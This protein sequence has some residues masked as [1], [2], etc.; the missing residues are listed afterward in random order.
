MSTPAPTPDTAPYWAAAAEGRL[1][2]QHCNACGR[3][4]FYPR[5]FCRHCFSPDVAWV[6]V[7]GNARLLSYVIARKPLRGF[8]PVSP[9]IAVVELDEGPRL[10]TNIVDI[11]PDPDLLVLDMPLRVRFHQRD[12]MTLPVFAPTGDRPGVPT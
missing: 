3:H 2:I 12:D 1:E 11:D 7:T 5:P 9:V 8:E 6:E 10:M 4:Y